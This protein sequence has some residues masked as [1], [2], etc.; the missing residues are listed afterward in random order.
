MSLVRHV[1]LGRRLGHDQKQLCRVHEVDDVDKIA[2]AADPLSRKSGIRGNRSP[3]V[4]V[5]GGP[6]AFVAPLMQLRVPTS[7]LCRTQRRLVS[8]M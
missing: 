4:T 8:A 5:N 6:L 3:N 1:K 2:H 7:S